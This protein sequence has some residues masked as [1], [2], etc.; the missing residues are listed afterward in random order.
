MRDAH[1]SEIREQ[2]ADAFIAF[3]EANTFDAVKLE[4]VN[5]LLESLNTAVDTFAYLAERY[6]V[7]LAAL[8]HLLIRHRLHWC[9][10]NDWRTVASRPAADI[11]PW[12]RVLDEA[13][14]ILAT[15]QGT[16]TTE[17]R[18][19]AERALHTLGASGEHTMTEDEA[20]VHLAVS[21]HRRLKADAAIKRPEETALSEAFEQLHHRAPATERR[22]RVQ[23]CSMMALPWRRRSGT[24]Q[25][26]VCSWR[27]PIPCERSPSSTPGRVTLNIRHATAPSSAHG[28]TGR[29]P[30]HA[31]PS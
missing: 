7:D 8:L 18:E 2:I 13:A 16:L 28:R 25:T 5:R 11:E 15:S 29:A 31:S 23:P 27:R 14:E 12:P 3:V 19:S 30:T 1:S 20:L 9:L 4:A 24:R 26:W 10:E 22:R 21:E 17:W 6:H